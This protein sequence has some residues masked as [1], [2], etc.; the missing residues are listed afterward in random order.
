LD[1]FIY[2]VRNHYFSRASGTRS[3]TER[4]NPYVYFKF[5]I[6]PVDPRLHDF[7]RCV[8]AEFLQNASCFTAQQCDIA[9]AI[10][11]WQVHPH[12]QLPRPNFAHCVVRL[13]ADG[14]QRSVPR[15]QLLNQN[16]QLRFAVGRSRLQIN[17]C[18]INAM[19]DRLPIRIIGRGTNDRGP[20]F[21]VRSSYP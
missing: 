10:D 4:N 2:A 9:V 5:T 15:C 20:M 21:F 1:P 12:T 17:Q 11:P 6:N 16:P 7:V 8:I 13:T 14:Q 19:P 3:A 18:Q